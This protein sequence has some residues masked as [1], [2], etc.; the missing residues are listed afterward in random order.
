MQFAGPDELAMTA[1]RRYRTVP[2]PS[3]L[4]RIHNLTTAERAAVESYFINDDGTR[5]IEKWLKIKARWIVES[6]VDGDG[7][8]H[9]T[10][11]DIDKV[12][13]YDCQTTDLIVDAIYEHNGV[14]QADREAMEKNYSE[15]GAEDFLRTA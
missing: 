1:R 10:M 14:S 11:A 15:A 4:Y 8:R 9:F 7:L 12:Q 6:L 13:S 2:T 3:G 5:D